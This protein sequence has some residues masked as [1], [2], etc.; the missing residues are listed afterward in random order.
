MKLLLSP[1][2]RNDTL[3]YVFEDDNTVTVNYNGELTETFKL[4]EI[5]NED[6]GSYEDDNELINQPEILPFQ[7]II[8]FEDIDG[9]RH[10]TVLRSHGSNPPHEVAWPD[11][12]EVE[13][14][15][16]YPNN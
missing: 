13:Y 15:T 11:W 1:Q 3:K 7:P 2:R 16:T 10:V 12:I 9:V 4:D 8:S 6:D 14:G 5:F